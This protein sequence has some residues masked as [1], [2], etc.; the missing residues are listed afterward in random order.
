M[1][2]PTSKTPVAKCLALAAYTCQMM[3][4]F[5]SSAELVELGAKLSVARDNLAA[6]ERNCA[7]AEAGMLP[8]R[9][10]VTHAD[11]ESD[12]GL[13]QSRRAAE[14]AD[15]E[16]HGPI[17]MHLFPEGTTPIVRLLGVA[18]VKQMKDLEGRYD[19]LM[20]RWADAQSEKD[21]ITALRQRY[22]QALNARSN[23][24]QALSNARSLRDLAKEDF[25]D[26]Y[27]EVANRVRALFPRNK[28]KQDLF[29]DTVTD[30]GSSE[31]E[32]ENAVA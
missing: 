21:K 30:R 2:I 19:G 8:A 24:A 32:T 28:K 9:V 1:E 22:E 4:R 20:S 25:L 18:Q 17:M 3:G 16:A 14:L 23:A 13:K 11:Y 26:V 5:P 29:F 12:E 10:T 6:A 15:G 7:V 27:A 31:P